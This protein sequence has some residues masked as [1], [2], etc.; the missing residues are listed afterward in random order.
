MSIT[1]LTRTTAAK[2]A[3]FA[4]DTSG[5]DDEALARF[6][7][8]YAITCDG[9]D[10]GILELPL[11][12]SVEPTVLKTARAQDVEKWAIELFGLTRQRHNSAIRQMK[13][14]GKVMSFE[15]GNV[16]ITCLV[17]VVPADADGKSRMATIKSDNRFLAKCKKLG[18]FAVS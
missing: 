9:F 14:R 10:V 13:L 16:G 8:L 12:L 17:P 7:L 2:R 5:A 4:E 15:L 6:A 18:C 11:D 1:E 3:E